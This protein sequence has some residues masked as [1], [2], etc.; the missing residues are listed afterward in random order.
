MHMPTRCEIAR[1]VYLI[2]SNVWY[3]LLIVTLALTSIALLFYEILFP[4]TDR[5]I[6]TYART[7]DLA[8]AYVFLTDFFV[9]LYFSRYNDGRT[10]FFRHNW[11]NL[12]SSIPVT[13]EVMSVL[14]VLRIVRATRVIRASMNFWF[15]NSRKRRVAQMSPEERAHAGATA[16]EC[17]AE[18]LNDSQ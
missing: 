12:I 2:Q 13:H 17:R 10:T 7:I 6:I 16:P 9:G 3:A 1:A 18:A 4:E 14:R 11:L 8:I 15:A 5:T